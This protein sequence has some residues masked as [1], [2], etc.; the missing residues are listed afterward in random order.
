MKNDLKSGFLFTTMGSFGTIIIQLI[1]NT[2][3]ARLLSP[4]DYGLV[5]IVLVFLTFFQF[6]SDAGIG[7]AIIQNQRLNKQDVNV[8]F[9]LSIFI[10]IGLSLLFGGSSFLISYF[11]HNRELIGLIWVSTLALLFYGLAVVPNAVTRKNKMFKLIGLT[12]LLSALMNGIFG[13][14]LALMGFGPYALVISTV[15]SAFSGFILR[16]L[17]SKVKITRTLSIAPIN[18]IKEF[19]KNQLLFNTLQYFSKNVDNLLIGK[20][21]SSE[22]LGIYNKAYSLTSYPVTMMNAVFNPVLQ[23]VLAEFQDDVE[24][25]KNFYLKFVRVLLTICLPISVFCAL[26]GNSIITVLFG[27]QWIESI[28]PFQVLSISIWMQIM[29][30]TSNSIFQSTN[31]TSKMLFTGIISSTCLFI[32]VL[33][34]VFFGNMLT[35]ALGVLVGTLISLIYTFYILIKKIL[36]ATIKECIYSFNYGF[37]LSIIIGVCLIM[38]SSF[39]SINNVFIDLF[40]RIIIFIVVFMVVNLVSGEYK[41]IIKILKKD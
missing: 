24:Y 6:L 28:M 13:I 23:P 9:T 38:Y 26:S 19:T 37:F 8:L 39:T 18:E 20:F 14:I 15:I 33:I 41:Q 17:F 36:K 29:I 7:S 34:G 1:I 40:V 5:A 22:A 30:M 27:S 31:Q 16:L 25:I 2:F 32:G 10:S 35:V 12:Q 4:N 21:F 3:L 11:Y